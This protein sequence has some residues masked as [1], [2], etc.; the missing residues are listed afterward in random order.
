MCSKSNA[1]VRAGPAWLR[2]SAL[3]VKMSLS[4]NTVRLM[5][6]ARREGSQRKHKEVGRHS[7]TYCVALGI[8]W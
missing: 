4:E 7:H 8:A 2:T 6:V 3:R 1:T 5:P